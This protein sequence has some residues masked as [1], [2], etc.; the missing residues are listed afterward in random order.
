MNKK[1]F[2]A[3]GG[4]VIVLI[5]VY[6][7]VR[8]NISPAQQD[9]QIAVSC[10]NKT[11]FRYKNPSTIFPVIIRD[12]STNFSIAT[13]VLGKLVSDSSGGNAVSTQVRN[14]AQKLRDDLDQD[15]IFFENTLKAYF[16][17]S[18]NDPCN[19]SLRYMY[20]SYIKEMTEKVIA[21]KQFVKQISSPA[22]ATGVDTATAAPNVIVAA[23]DTTKTTDTKGDNSDAKTK[24]YILKDRL[25]L[26]NAITTLKKTNEIS[27]P[28]LNPDTYR[29]IQKVQP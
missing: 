25:I 28:T 21:L 29:K 18:N 16:L 11:V 17:A 13:G 15:N 12:Y 4:L 26:S 7:I 20:I 22:P 27:K 6:F 23:I 5:L 3:F 2:F 14:D 1:Y 19:D 10:A 8:N 24:V 9:E